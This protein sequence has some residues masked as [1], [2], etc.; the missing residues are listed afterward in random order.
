M[1]TNFHDP[2]DE[3]TDDEFDEDTAR[4]FSRPM[5][6]VQLT[7]SQDF[8]DRIKNLAEQGGLD[9]VNEL[10]VHALN[11]GIRQILAEKSRVDSSDDS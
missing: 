9:P 5:T 6:T 4:L 7:I 2:Y 8:Y 1:S 11:L 3:M 10:M